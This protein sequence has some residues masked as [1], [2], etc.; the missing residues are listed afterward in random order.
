MCAFCIE[1]E[2]KQKTATQRVRPLLIEKTTI[3][4]YHKSLRLKS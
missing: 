2:S 4:V 1:G 3:L